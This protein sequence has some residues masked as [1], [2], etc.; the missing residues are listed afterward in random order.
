[1]SH[2]AEGL[3]KTPTQLFFSEKCLDETKCSCL[4]LLYALKQNT[5]KLSKEELKIG[6]KLLFTGME[7]FKKTHI[8]TLSSKKAFRSQKVKV[9]TKP[10]TFPFY[11]Q[12]K[13]VNSAETSL[14]ELFE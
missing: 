7:P 8:T 2:H 5:L 9:F 11:V 6:V 1:L 13:V 3:K 4:A 12:G 14:E 10:E